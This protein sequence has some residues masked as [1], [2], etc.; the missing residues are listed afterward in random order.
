MCVSCV[1]EKVKC[2]CNIADGQ[3]K[4][5][6]RK[7]ILPKLLL[8][9]VNRLE[10]EGHSGRERER[11]EVS[12]G[13]LLDNRLG[14]KEKSSQVQGEHRF[15]SIA[16]GSRVKLMLGAVW[17][18]RRDQVDCQV[19]KKY[20]NT[21]WVLHDWKRVIR[22]QASMIY[23]F[24]HKRR[25]AQIVC[26]SIAYRWLASSGR[27]SPNQRAVRPVSHL[28]LWTTLWCECECV[29][30]QKKERAA[31]MVIT[32]W[33]F[34]M[35]AHPL[36]LTF[37]WWATMWVLNECKWI[38]RWCRWSLS[39]IVQEWRGQMTHTHT[40]IHIHIRKQVKTHFT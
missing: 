4:K 2:N 9:P 24:S 15:Y 22:M 3:W 8:A 38:I 21:W 20:E 40:F 25:I 31:M 14:S 19:A 17:V 33:W 6:Q 13:D 36:V 30:S 7:K 5:K 39:S 34:M 26:S 16:E 12:L 32:A 18:I 29:W 27:R 1:W 35:N 10:Y 37:Q 28:H 23:Y 11:E